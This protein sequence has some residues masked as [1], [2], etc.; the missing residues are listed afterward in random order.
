MQDK[1]QELARL[2][3]TPVTVTTIDHLCI[4]LTAARE[5]HH[6]IFFNL[7]HSCLVIDEADF[8]DDFSQHNI[9]MLLRALRLLNVPVLMMSATVPESA[10]RLYSMSGFEVPPIYEDQSDNSRVRCRLTRV[11][12][13]TRPDD[14]ASL[15]QCAL[16]G[17]PTIIYANTV[18]RA[19]DYYRWFHQQNRKFT[20]DN[21]VLYHSRFTEPHKVRKEKMLYDMLG[22][23]AWDPGKKTAHGVAIL[24]QIG[25][26]SVNI[27]ADFMLSELCPIDRLTQRVGRLSR[28]GNCPGSLFVLDPVRLKKDKQE[29]LY[30]A[31][32]GEFDPGQ[33]WT[34]SKAFARS[35]ELLKDG[36]YTAKDFVDLVDEL[37]PDKPI[38]VSAL[39]RNNCDA[40]ERCLRNNWLLLPSETVEDDEDSTQYWRSRNI[41]PQRTIYAD[42]KIS[43]IEGLEE[44]R[45]DTWSKFR[46]FQLRHGIQCH[47]YEFNRAITDGLLIE[48]R[49][50]TIFTIGD[51]HDETIWVAPRQYYDFDLGL[52]LFEDE[53]D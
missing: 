11:G 4:C 41:P 29:E 10:R 24:T 51:D 19:Q 48:S 53:D 27:S 23:E 33:G 25:E 6:G 21:V 42:Y 47:V 26:L 46:A 31:P 52:H 28:F 32:Y 38:L 8:Y 18:R 2:L 35:A 45:P 12:K 14:V 7:A 43:G 50:K 40:M 34:M 1:E 20:Q 30:P 13:V 3:E 22:K 5:D 39:I 17:K 16:E 15:L 44:A 36:E 37:Y 49:D 9:V